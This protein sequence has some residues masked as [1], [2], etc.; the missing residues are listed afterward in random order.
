[1][2]DFKQAV[3][4]T[5]THEGGYV[6]NPADSGGPTK[7][8]I[9][10]ADMP[11]QNIQDLTEDQAIGYYTEH[12]WKPLY[13]Q[14]NSQGVA[15]KLFDLGI[16]FGVGTA[17]GILQLTLGV[18]VDHNFGPNTLTATNQAEETGL[19]KSYKANLVTHVFNIANVNPKDRIFLN[20]WL[21]RID[22]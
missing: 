9:T 18:T 19:L 22:S 10:Q 4:K 21:A 8:G 20:G 5:L 16:L 17:V 13:S 14:I 12:Y 7:Y 2:S 11:G 3:Q 1:M 6:N 15:E